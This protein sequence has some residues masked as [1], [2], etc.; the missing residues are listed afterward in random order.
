MK[1]QTRVLLM[2]LM[3]IAGLVLLI[4]IP[5]LALIMAGLY[6]LY[7]MSVS[8]LTFAEIWKRMQSRPPS[9]VAATSAVSEQQATVPPPLIT[10]AP[11]MTPIEIQAMQLAI[12]KKQL[13][14]IRVIGVFIVTMM[15]AQCVRHLQ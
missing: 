15:L 9:Q 11:L 14:W 1:T 4:C 8:P 6:G 12:Q 7:R 5:Q 2:I 10:F 13:Y 3:G